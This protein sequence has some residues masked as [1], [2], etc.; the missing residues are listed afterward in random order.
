MNKIKI[1]GVTAVIIAIFAIS[2]FCFPTP[3]SRTQAVV[4]DRPVV[5]IDAANSDF[6]RYPSSY[7][8][9]TD[10]LMKWG[11]ELKYAD[12]NFTAAMFTD[13]DILVMSKRYMNLT[14]AAETALVNWFNSGNKSILF[15]GDGDYSSSIDAVQYRCCGHEQSIRSD[16]K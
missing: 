11:Y 16:W 6:D 8:L 4:Q 2:F 3:L 9:F 10:T 7:T 15:G 14:T 13:V 5:L 12:D 1:R